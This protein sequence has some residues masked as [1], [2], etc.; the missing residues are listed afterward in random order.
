[1]FQDGNQ[2]QVLVDHVHTEPVPP[3]SRAAAPVPRE[4]D[5]LVLE[6]LRK[7]P[8]DRPA[9]AQALLDRINELN[10]ERRWNNGHAQAWW[11]AR[12]PALAGPLG[13]PS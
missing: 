11:Q 6:C 7:I 12:L 3:S 4:I 9:D 1:V 8:A 10:F 2:M 5:A 13:S